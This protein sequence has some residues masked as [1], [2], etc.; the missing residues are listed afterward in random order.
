MKSSTRRTPLPRSQSAPSRAIA[1]P[2]PNPKTLLKSLLTAAIGSAIGL[3]AFTTNAGVLMDSPTDQ[4]TISPNVQASSDLVWDLAKQ[5]SDSGINSLLTPEA[6][7]NTADPDFASSLALL[8]ENLAKQQQTRIESINEATETLEEH[9]ALFKESGSP[10][11]LS[12]GLISAVQLQILSESNDEFHALPGVKE[13]IDASIKHAKLAEEN[14]KWL[15]ASELYY[16]LNAI[17][18]QSGDFREDVDRLTRR[19]TMIRLYVPKR[20]WELRNERRLAEELEGLPPYNPFG[21][22]YTD[23]LQGIDSVTVR[24]AIQR[25]AAQ[26]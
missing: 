1:L 12:K 3:S 16:R 20:L 25:A 9:L 19:L 21:D 2:Q 8:Q 15:I 17:Y 7:G 18:D 23:K 26:H 4:P 5:G 6:W 14:G 10:I 13:I 11:E 22:L 24:T